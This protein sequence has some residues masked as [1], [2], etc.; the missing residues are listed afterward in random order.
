MKQFRIVK[1]SW[2]LYFMLCE[3]E[4]RCNKTLTFSPDAEKLQSDGVW[5]VGFGL[6]FLLLTRFKHLDLVGTMIIPGS[7]FLLHENPLRQPS[8]GAPLQW[9]PRVNVL[10]LNPRAEWEISAERF[11][12]KTQWATLSAQRQP[13][14][15]L[16]GNGDS[17]KVCVAQRCAET[18]LEMGFGMQAFQEL[19][20]DMIDSLFFFPSPT[21]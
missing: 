11:P 7:T 12:T 3:S 10:F 2:K 21:L 5:V 16:A 8:R 18:L 1:N 6:V 20:I 17:S 13:G 14:V 19:Q 4:G 15:R 9:P